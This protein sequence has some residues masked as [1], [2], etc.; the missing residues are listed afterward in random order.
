MSQSTNFEITAWGARLEDEDFSKNR[1]SI[2][3]PFVPQPEIKSAKVYAVENSVADLKSIIDKLKGDIAYFNL[4]Q[5]QSM[6]INKFSYLVS[7][8][9]EVVGKLEKA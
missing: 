1:L 7:E 8:L 6:A 3:A 4:F 2:A 9:T 5:N